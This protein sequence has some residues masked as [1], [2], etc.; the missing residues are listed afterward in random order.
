MNLRRY[1]SNDSG[2]CMRT[3]R[4]AAILIAVLLLTPVP[5]AYPADGRSSGKQVELPWSE[6]DSMVVGKRVQTVLPD[7]TRLD[8]TVRS[9]DDDSLRMLVRKS[10]NVELH[11]KGE[12]TIPR[13]SISV[14]NRVESGGRKWRTV[15]AV[16]GGWLGVGL[17]TAT[18]AAI[19]NGLPERGDSMGG[20]A[21][22][23]AISGVGGGTVG[24]LAGRE[25]DKKKPTTII[26]TDAME[27]KSMSQRPSEEA[28][29][30]P[31]RYLGVD[32]QPSY[33]SVGVEMV[34]AMSQLREKFIPAPS[35][36]KRPDIYSRDA[37]IGEDLMLVENFR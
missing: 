11:P 36:D 31:R 21:A 37:V 27:E 33:P 23:L 29:D 28:A 24:Y 20:F 25:I 9:V 3:R 17:A 6:L 19:A 2:R 34:P 14:L 8:G 22:A 35:T 10:S 30:I 16:A 13:A 15:G 4:C 5:L 32:G 18:T 12:I 26:V 7:G 1:Y